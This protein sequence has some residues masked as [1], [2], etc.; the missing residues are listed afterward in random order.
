[1]LKSRITHCR[2]GRKKICLTAIFF[3]R[4]IFWG[5]VSLINLISL[6]N[7]ISYIC[8]Y[9]RE[10]GGGIFSFFCNA[11]CR[12]NKS[13]YLCGRNGCSAAKSRGIRST[14]RERGENPR[15]YPLLYFPS[16]S[17]ANAIAPCEGEKARRIRNKSED[18]PLRIPYCRR[19]REFTDV[20]HPNIRL[21][22][23]MFIEP[24][25]CFS[26]HRRVRTV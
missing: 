7:S 3:R 8:R 19:L 9:G 15:Q 14:K 12:I 10:A 25:S 1:M 24:P 23:Q 22:A 6:I 2:I 4:R 21:S 11:L 18:L 16:T 26:S 5:G 13:L 17:G 20:V